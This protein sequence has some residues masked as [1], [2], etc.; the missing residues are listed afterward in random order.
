[1]GVAFKTAM[2][3]VNVATQGSGAGIN[4]GFISQVETLNEVDNV[5][6]LLTGNETAADSYLIGLGAA[7]L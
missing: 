6:A 1:M 4:Q 7:A 5:L 2:A 3:S